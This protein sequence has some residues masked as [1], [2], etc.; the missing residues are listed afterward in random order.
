MA[1]IKRRFGS[2]KAR[3]KGLA[4]VLAS[5]LW[6]LWCIICIVSLALLCAVHKKRYN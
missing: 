1:V 5:I 2:G 6:R 4:R 3:Y